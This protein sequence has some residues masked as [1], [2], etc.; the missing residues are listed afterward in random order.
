MT[1]KPN[2]TTPNPL[3]PEWG[4]PLSP[5]LTVRLSN[6]NCWGRSQGILMPPWS[7]PRLS[8]GGWNGGMRVCDKSGGESM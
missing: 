7:F 6:E 5:P 1:Y 8:I 3:K 4:Q 2:S